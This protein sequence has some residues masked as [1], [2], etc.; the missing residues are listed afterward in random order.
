[1]STGAAM[2]FVVTYQGFLIASEGLARA[3]V[4]VS[5]LYPTMLRVKRLLATAP[6][7]PSM[8]KHP[9]VISGSIELSNVAFSYAPNLPP[10][11]RGVSLRIEP[12]QSVAIVGPSGCGKSTLMNLLL[13]VDHPAGGVVL[14]DGHDLLQLDR[15][16]L[17]RQIGVVRQGGRLLA[18]SI[19]E[20]IMGL[21]A[22][23]LA[24]AW[25]AAEIA[26]IADDIRAMP[27]GM[28]T[29]LNEG[30]SALSGGQVQRLLIARALAGK[31]RMVVLDEATSALDNV[32]QSIVSRNIDRLGITRVIVAHRLSTV[33]QSDMIHFLEQGRVAESGTAASLIAAGGRF[34]SFIQRQ[35]L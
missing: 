25:H 17:R 26:S 30:T 20:N 35:S 14:Y 31:P 21:H 3:V 19:H 10:V 18:G 12:G 7:N 34:A 1:M 4:Q 27:M 23:S 16:L 24:D 29:V 5:G 13:G 15:R 6:D 2:G 8:R 33:M 11:L 28:H 9:G 22:G 32:T